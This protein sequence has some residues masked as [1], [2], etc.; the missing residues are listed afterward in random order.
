MVY[1]GADVHEDEVPIGD[2]ALRL[3]QRL[4]RQ[5]RNGGLVSP[6]LLLR[7]FVEVL[8]ALETSRHANATQLS[9]MSH[10]LRWCYAMLSC[11]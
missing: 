6:W 8:A 10:S 1:S 4:K 3:R 5:A 11:E 2:T 9:A 7:P